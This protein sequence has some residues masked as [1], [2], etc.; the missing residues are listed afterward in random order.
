MVAQL[1]R[2]VFA[3]E[4]MVKTEL[5]RGPLPTAKEAYSTAFST[6]WASIAETFLNALISMADTAMVG[7]VGPAAIAAVG[8]VTQPRFIV[9][10]LI[11]SLNMA[12]TSITARRRGENDPDGAVRCLKQSLILSISAAVLLA[13]IAALVRTP[14]L[15]FA[16]A[17]ADTLQPALE[18]F[19]VILLGTPINA[20]GMT[21]S[22]AQR[23]IGETRVSMVINLTANSVN[24]LFNWL[25]IGGRMG[26]PAL[27]TKGAAIATVI[28]WSFGL[29][30]AVLSIANRRS[31][32]FVFS[33]EIPWGFDKRTMGA[34]YKVVSGSFLEQICLRIG[35]VAYSVIVAGLGTM[36]FAAHHICMNVLSLSFS[37]GEGFGIAASSL[38]GQNLGAKRPDLSIVYGKVCHRMSFFTCAAMFLLFTFAGEP[39]VRMFTS[40]ESIIAV[41]MPIMVIAGVIL[42]GQASQMIY[43]GSLR[44]AGDTRY[45]AIVSMICILFFRPV[46]AYLLAYRF[47]FALTGAWI[48]L[49]IDQYLRLI[50]TERRFSSGK[51]MSIEL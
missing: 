5:R 14:L 44:G 49:I 3:P 41:C 22:A 36:L 42:F 39:M 7:V 16:G 35:F 37:F 21:I 32:L 26:F 15:Q 17:Q 11:L 48:A 10:T 40:D 24:L 6:A 28:G 30:L 1:A 20:L 47:G 8:L 9:L 2:R 12:V 29:V 33:R 18:Y 51:W 45:T 27:G 25:L 50:L 13:G 38:V 19:E 4:F 23:G 31:F 46:Q 34:I 43:M